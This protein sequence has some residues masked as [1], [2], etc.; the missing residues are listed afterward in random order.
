MMQ[1][2]DRI[3]G[4]DVGGTKSAVIVGTAA[5]RVVARSQFASQ[6]TARRGA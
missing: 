1:P 4:F 3:L 2:Q 6:A 5:G